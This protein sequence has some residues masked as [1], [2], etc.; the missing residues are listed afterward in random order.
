MFSFI[1]PSILG[2]TER[3]AAEKIRRLTVN[4][5]SKMELRQKRRLNRIRMKKDLREVPEKRNNVIKKKKKKDA[6]LLAPTVRKT[7]DRV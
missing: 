2:G 3:M 7:E 5:E 6:E 4:T 1:R